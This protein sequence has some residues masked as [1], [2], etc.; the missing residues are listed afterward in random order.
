[1]NKK[2]HDI[3]LEKKNYLQWIVIR[4]SFLEFFLWRGYLIKGKVDKTRTA[5]QLMRTE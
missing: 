5:K 4:I 3:F 1:M 2:F